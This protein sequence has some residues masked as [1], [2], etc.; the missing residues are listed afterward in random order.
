MHFYLWCGGWQLEQKAC[1]NTRFHAIVAASTAT[2]PPN[3]ALA[4]L[5]HQQQSHLPRQ[6]VHVLSTGLLEADVLTGD[7]VDAL[8]GGRQVTSRWQMVKKGSGHAAGRWQAG[9]RRLEGARQ[10]NR[11]AEGGRWQ[12]AGGRWK[13]GVTHNVWKVVRLEKP[14]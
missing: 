1:L 10:V 5:L 8:R 7:V 2:L 9:G 4:Q 12:V 3:I 14:V 13:H 11:R 6:L